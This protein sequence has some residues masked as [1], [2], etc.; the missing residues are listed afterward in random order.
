MTPISV[1]II[2]RNE[3]HIISKTLQSVHA[4]TDDIVVVD[5]G[6]TD[7]TQQLCRDNKA[8]VI[9]TAWNGFGPNKNKGIA[10]ATYD[11]ILSIDSDEMPD[12][13]LLLSLR[14][15]DFAE[16]EAVYN[17]RFKTFLGNKLIRFGEWGKDAHIRLFNR[18][19]VSWNNAAVHEQLIIPSS[20][21]VKNLKGYIL[22]YTM[23]DL[24]DYATKMTSYA[25]LNAE[26]NFQK[27]KK[28]GWVKRNLSHRF[29]FFRNYFLKLGFLDGV[30]GYWIARM[31][32]YYTFLK[33]AR[34]YELNR[35][36]K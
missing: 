8:T 25:L 24:A 3:A 12:E 20:T 34:L 4:L 30:E 26:G 13:E 28:A 15:I 10:A 23:K 21:S 5:S 1:V 2:A 33:Y 9:E 17:I 35:T 16:T 19:K 6:S 22:H 14:S 11:W 27:G 31:T 36:K 18:T 7:G 29:S 32:S